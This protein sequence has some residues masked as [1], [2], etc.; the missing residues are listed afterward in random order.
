MWCEHF[1]KH[2]F[3]KNVI[4]DL[5]SENGKDLVSK[6]INLNSG[7]PSDCFCWMQAGVGFCKTQCASA[8]ILPGDSWEI[9]GLIL[10]HLGVNSF[11]M[12]FPSTPFF[13]AR[14]WAEHVEIHAW[15]YKPFAWHN[16]SP[17]K[18][19]GMFTIECAAG[20]WWEYLCSTRAWDVELMLAI[21]T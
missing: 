14:G 19:K 12:I 7:M 15:F 16:Y 6:S 20:G 1:E 4:T 21:L 8:K 9:L 3:L 17:W 10:N 18:H 11:L 2:V 13:F 5:Y